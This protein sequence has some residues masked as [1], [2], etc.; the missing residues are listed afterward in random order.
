MQQAGV[1]AARARRT[2]LGLLCAGGLAVAASA[3]INSNLQIEAGETFELGGGQAGSFTVT[4]RNTGPV[5][6]EVLGKAEGAAAG[7]MRA[8]VAPGARLEADFAP[9]E[10]ALLR[11]TSNTKA[12]RLKL[13]ITGDTAA[14]GMSY[15]PNP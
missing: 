12:A 8:T 6:V 2:A 14:L 15:A 11:N 3:A 4:G 1:M 5:A 13:R 9:G 7:V 10:M